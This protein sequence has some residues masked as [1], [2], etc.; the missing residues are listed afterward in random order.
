LRVLGRLDDALGVAGE[1]ANNK[2]KLSNRNAH[3]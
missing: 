3:K 2:I 1:I